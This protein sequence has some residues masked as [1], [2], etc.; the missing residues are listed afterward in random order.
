MSIRQAGDL[1]DGRATAPKLLQDCLS[2]MNG[3]LFKW[4]RVI[5]L[6]G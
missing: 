6:Q 4:K 1:P 2:D 5:K 3:K